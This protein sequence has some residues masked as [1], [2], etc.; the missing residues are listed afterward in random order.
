MTRTHA[1]Q[2]L[3]EHGG[4]STAELLEITGWSWN[5]VRATLRNLMERGAVESVPVGPHRNIYVLA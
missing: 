5:A 1:L 3:L 2:R 4:L